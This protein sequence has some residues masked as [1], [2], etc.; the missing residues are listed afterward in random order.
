[1]PEEKETKIYVATLL[2]LYYG[3]EPQPLHTLIS[4]PNEAMEQ[5]AARAEQSRR[6]QGYKTASGYQYV[7]YLGQLTHQVPPPPPPAPVELTKI[8]KILV[9]VPRRAAPKLKSIKPA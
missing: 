7:I 8:E 1:M 6:Q 3:K 4:M 5:L 9:A 2:Q